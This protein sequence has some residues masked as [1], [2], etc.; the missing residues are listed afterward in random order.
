MLAAR[1]TVEFCYSVMYSDANEIVPELSIY[2]VFKGVAMSSVA[3][4]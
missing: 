2:H 3:V 1:L 4:Y